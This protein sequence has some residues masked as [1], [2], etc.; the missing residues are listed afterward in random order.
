[1]NYV[2]THHAPNSYRVLFSRLYTLVWGRI[3]AEALQFNEAYYVVEIDDCDPESLSAVQVDY[4]PAFNIHNILEEHFEEL[5]PYLMDLTP[6]QADIIL[7]R[8]RC[9][10]N[11][12][13]ISVILGVYTQSVAKQYHGGLNKL[14]LLLREGQQPK[15]KK[16]RGRGPKLLPYRV[17]VDIIRD[18]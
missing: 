12:R 18:P 14:A 16:K 6:V 10:L 8:H 3:M 4:T 11:F 1:M 17:V 13:M 15:T 9:N 7:M 5:L 2:H